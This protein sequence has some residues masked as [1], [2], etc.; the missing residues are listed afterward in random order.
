MKD[1]LKQLRKELGLTQQQFA[2][3]IGTTQNVVANYEIGRRNPS[4]SVINNMC[5]TF[6]VNEEWLRN[7]DGL[8]FMETPYDT[9]G[10]LKQEYDLD[11]FSYG[12][13]C[14]YLKLDDAKRKI[15]RQ[16]FHD[17]LSHDD[18]VTDLPQGEEEMDIDAMVEEYRKEL[19]LEKKIKEKSAVLPKSG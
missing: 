10:K 8:M 12:L 16:Y 4:N 19:I 15:V 1:R 2:K 6:N 17:V 11:D 18:V 9:L 7:G 3:K 14:E 13:I 5:K